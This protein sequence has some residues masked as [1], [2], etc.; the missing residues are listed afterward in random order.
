M[1]IL[2]ISFSTRGAMGDYL[3]LL[4]QELA[5]KEAIF[6]LV[7]SYFD[8]KIENTKTFKFKMGDSKLISLFCLLNP[9]TILKILRFIKK[10]KPDVIHLIFGEG[11]PPMLILAPYLKKKKIPLVLTIHDPEIHP[12]GTIDKINNFLRKFVVKSAAAIHIHT[13]LF[14]QKIKKMG[15]TDNK[16]FIIPH[17]SFAPIFEKYKNPNI[18]KE[19]WIL[20]FGRLE[21]YKGLEYFVEAGLKFKDDFKFIIAG[22]G[23]LEEQ[24]LNKIE[25]N[26]KRFIL[27]NKFLSNE[28]VAN[29]FQQSKVCVL[30]Y[31]QATQSSIPLISAYFDV[32]VVAAKVG[33]FVEEIPLING[34]LVESQN[35]DSLVDG[36]YKAIN[37]KPIYPKDREF[38]ILSDKF[39]FLYQ[40]LL[41][42]SK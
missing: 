24:L 2:L 5:K 13:E 12:G 15:I 6:L 11:Y 40:N 35:P 16:I 22:P 18:K 29:L 25:Q 39:I 4:A 42:K 19:N 32:P 1:K 9:L 27:I 31:I 38:S 21:K 7:P 28:E 20:F 14:R 23:E 33:N 17:G 37:L 34:V 10:E 26:S 8:R 30:P 36:I 3:F 41:N